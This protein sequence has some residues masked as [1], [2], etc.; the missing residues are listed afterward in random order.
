M[1]RKGTTGFTAKELAFADEL[2]KYENEWVAIVRN[3]ANE[4]IVGSG[5]R[6]LD[7]KAEADAKGIKNPVYLKVPSTTKVF[8][9]LFTRH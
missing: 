4:K 3:G 1:S 7:A 5:K 8:I 9:P 6:L 2:A